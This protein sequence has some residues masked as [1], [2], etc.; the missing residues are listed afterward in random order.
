MAKPDKVPYIPYRGVKH[1]GKCRLMLLNT[2]S[3]KY[4]EDLLSDYMRNEVI[5]MTIA[6]E[7]WHTNHNWNAN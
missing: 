6:T 4:K 1:T 2:Q 5:D 7:T 3:I